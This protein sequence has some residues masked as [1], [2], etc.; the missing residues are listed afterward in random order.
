MEVAATSAVSGLDGV[1]AVALH[2]AQKVLL[3]AVEQC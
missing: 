3:I 2:L 1:Q